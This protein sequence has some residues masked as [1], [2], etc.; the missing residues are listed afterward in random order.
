MAQHFVSRGRQ[1]FEQVDLID[2]NSLR[3]P[4]PKPLYS[5]VA[6]NSAATGLINIASDLDS[7]IRFL[8]L[9][10][11]PA[12]MDEF[13]LTLGYTAWIS[14]LI[15]EQKSIIIEAASGTS[16]ITAEEL[17]A[18][19]AVKA[20][21]N[22]AGTG[23]AGID[24]ATRRLE[25]VLIARIIK[26]VRPDLAASIDLAARTMPI[27]QSSPK[28]WLNMPA[29]PLP[30]IGSYQMPCLRPYFSKQTPPLKGDGITVRSMGTLLET[31]AD[32]SS[33]FLAHKLMLSVDADSTL[34][35]EPP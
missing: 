30:L 17:L 3:P 22:F 20:P 35:I 6:Q 16:S 32:R 11:H 10:Y 21:F 15:S 8:P 13:V 26:N 23:H 5:A 19:I 33:P 25:N 34:A 24:Q 4:W 12:D 9:A 27:S 18:E 14:S 1:T 28:T 7:T 2:E 31:E 29:M